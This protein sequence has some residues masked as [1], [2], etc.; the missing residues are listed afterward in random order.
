MNSKVP[1]RKVQPSRPRGFALVVTLSL[2]VLLTLL[3]VGL[4]GL[5]EQK[6]PMMLFSYYLRPERDT[7][8][9]SKAWLWD[10][11]AIIYRWPPDNS[12]SSL[13]HRQF[14]MKVLGLDTWE[15]PYVQITPDNQAY[16]GGGVRAD[17][18][19]PFFTFRS[20]PLTP[21]QSLA[22]LQHACA[23][24]FR[25]YWKDSPIATNNGKFPAD[26]Y[27][28]DGYLYFTI[29]A[30]GNATDRNGKV[31]AFAWCEATV[32]RVPDYLDSADEPEIQDLALRSTANRTFGRKFKVVGFRWLNP[33]E[34]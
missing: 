3:A 16:W 26:A 28:L 18:G 20:V 23:N 34:V 30:Y 24:G 12:I 22:S 17:F 7:A 33:T 8:T 25:R 15:T 31:L 21:P 4:L 9:P 6:I 29:R 11:P 32:Q 14:E 5:A 13:L 10:N 19:V 27:A 1:I 2:M